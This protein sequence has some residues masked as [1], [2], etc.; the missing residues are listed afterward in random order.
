M[1]LKEVNISSVVVLE[2]NSNQL[3]MIVMN[4]EITII[5]H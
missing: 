2:K 3:A 4:I 1:A 5:R